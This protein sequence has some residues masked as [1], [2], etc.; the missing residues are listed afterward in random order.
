MLKATATV[1]G[2]EVFS[3]IL[4]FVVLVITLRDLCRLAQYYQLSPGPGLLNT[5]Q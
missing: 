4:S 5:I 1:P 2:L 3:A